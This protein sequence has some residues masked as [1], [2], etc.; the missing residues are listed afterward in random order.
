MQYI[1][2]YHIYRVPLPPRSV[3]SCFRQVH[4]TSAQTFD[5]SDADGVVELQRG[6][7]NV[8][9]REGGPPWRSFF[10]L[11]AHKVNKDDEVKTSLHG[12]RDLFLNQN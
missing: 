10:L 6:V 2:I 1:F 4:M 8:G 11:G 5:A 12:P 7:K 9:S 3:P